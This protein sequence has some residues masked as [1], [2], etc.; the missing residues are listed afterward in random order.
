MKYKQNPRR[1][2]FMSLRSKLLQLAVLPFAVSGLVVA[3]QML[4]YTWI[5]VIMPKSAWTILV[6]AIPAK[7]WYGVWLATLNKGTQAVV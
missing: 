7:V 6:V 1:W 5:A 2:Q 3:T 4:A